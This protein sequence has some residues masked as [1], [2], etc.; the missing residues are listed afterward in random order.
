MLTL[1]TGALHTKWIRDIYDEQARSIAAGQGG[2]VPNIAPAEC[3]GGTDAHGGD[4]PASCGAPPWAIAAIVLP[5]KIWRYHGDVQILERYYS[6]MQLFMEWLQ[7]TA[8]NST[9]LVT[10]GGL[11][12]WCPP[13]NVVRIT[14]PL[15]IWIDLSW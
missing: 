12:D 6:R 9:G 11:A 3:P 4:C 1:D 7:S 5:Y 13:A 15:A 14:S 2:C 8:D 10:H